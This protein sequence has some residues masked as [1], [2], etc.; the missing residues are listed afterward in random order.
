MSVVF[1]VDP[2]ASLD[3]GIDTTVGL[4]HAVQDRGC[5]VWVTEARDL[6]IVSGRAR[7]L[8]RAVRLAP[9]SPAGDCRW[10]VADPWFLSTTREH[11]WLD[12]ADA[13]FMRTEPPVD[14]TYVNATLVLD[15]VDPAR[16][17]MVNDPRGLRVC[18]EHLL[19][20][21][22]PELVPPTVVS[23]DARTIL[24]FVAEQ[25][26]AVLKPIDGFAGHGVL[27]L[28]RQDPNLRSLLEIST[29]D[30]RRAVLVQRYLPEVA[31]GNKRIFVLDG[32]AVAGV[33]RFPLAEDF[34]IGFPGAAAPI[35]NRD[36]HIC[37]RLAPTLVRY[38]LRM[39]GLDV[40]GEHLI[41]VNITSPGALRKADG[42]L[43][44]TLCA[45][46]VDHVLPT[47]ANDPA[48]DRAHNTRRSA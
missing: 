1:V 45:D 46:L 7:A 8:A 40:I 38:G 17:V 29:L 34:R 33:F 6:E 36:R 48:Q 20:L 24:D 28:D 44:T 3:A 25:G 31:G 9:T 47:P 13:V 30:G 18:S 22:F 19:P 23:A 42:L 32:E 39:V 35:T 5:A 15:L 12:S 37:Q 14:E 41:E 26:T 43:G 21:Q 11:V 4:M 2:L 27:R 10:T 16:T